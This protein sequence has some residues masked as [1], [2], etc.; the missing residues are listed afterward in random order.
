MFD[1]TTCGEP[2]GEGSVNTTCAKCW[3]KSLE[4]VRE[5]GRKASEDRERV[6][7]NQFLKGTGVKLPAK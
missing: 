3:A 1:C 4:D 6:F 7:W 5:A 2:L